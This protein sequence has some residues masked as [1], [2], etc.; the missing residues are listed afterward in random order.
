MTD[1]WV[2]AQFAAR[3]RRRMTALSETKKS[4]QREKSEKFRT[5]EYGNYNRTVYVGVDLGKKADYTSITFLEPFLPIEL[6]EEQEDRFVYHV[7]RIRRLPLETPYPKVARLLRKTWNQLIESP[8]FDYVYVVVDEGGV[9]AAVTDTVVEL[10]PNA[11]LYRV[12]LTGGIRPKWND[13]RS[14]NLPKPQMASTLISLFE[15][16]RLWADAKMKGQLE[17]LREELNNYERK[18]TDAGYD[19]FGSMKTGIHDDTV[20]A[21][22][23]AAWVAEDAGGGA[24]P[25][26]W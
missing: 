2:N 15:T 23:I 25:L 24:V 14:V 20:S 16:H 12:T 4:E 26:L 7:S 5:T 8:D 21:I 3:N 6:D 19:Q 10:I 9:G 1:S 17:E 18:I 11:E 22:G 13:P